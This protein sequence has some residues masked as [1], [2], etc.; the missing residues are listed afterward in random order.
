MHLSD[1][2]L[3]R[4]A[5]RGDLDSFRR[6]YERHYQMIVALARAQLHDPHL[7]EDAAQESFA[8]ACQQLA[9]LRDADRFPQ[10]L[11]TICRRTARRMLH[12]ATMTR[13]LDGEPPYG[14]QQVDETESEETQALVRQAVECLPAV[15]REVVCLRYYGGLSHEQ[16]A[17]ALGITTQAVHGRLQRAR[18]RL[19]HQ[20]S[21]S[22]LDYEPGR[23]TGP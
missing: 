8:V 20:I 3:V 12:T 23:K 13:P 19:A 18:R 4:A 9:R 2:D 6:L 10:W 11:G 15:H 22:D 7:A 17:A 5:C 21:A 14:G 16:I 1:G